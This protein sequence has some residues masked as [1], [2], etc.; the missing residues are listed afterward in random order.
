MKEVREE[1]PTLPMA[2]GGMRLSNR[3]RGIHQCATRRKALSMIK[4]DLMSTGVQVRVSMMQPNLKDVRNSPA[5]LDTV[6]GVGTRTRKHGLVARTNLGTKA[7]GMQSEFQCK[8]LQMFTDAHRVVTAACRFWTQEECMVPAIAHR[9]LKQNTQQI[10]SGYRCNMATRLSKHQTRLRGDIR[11]G[12]GRKGRRI[13]PKD[14]SGKSLIT[15]AMGLLGVKGCDQGVSSHKIGWGAP[16]Q[17]VV[18]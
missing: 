11:V 17:R 10:G 12:E 8:N 15:S 16:F 18:Q 2:A 3:I 9:I 13:F 7:R 14:S 4:E 6:Q 5:H 1:G